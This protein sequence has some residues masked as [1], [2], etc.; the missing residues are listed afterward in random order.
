MSVSVELSLRGAAQTYT[1]IRSD[2]TGES[3]NELVSYFL[4]RPLS[5]YPIKMEGQ[6]AGSLRKNDEQEE[7]SNL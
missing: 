4:F 7:D 5:V 6:I 3:P 2:E 1:S